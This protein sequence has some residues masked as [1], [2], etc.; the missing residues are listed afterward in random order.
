MSLEDISVT[1]IAPDPGL[2]GNAWPLMTEILE[3]VRRLLETGE[4]TAI[5]LSALPLTPAD[6]TW[7]KERLGMGQ[8]R[9]QLE[10]EGLSSLDETAC[11][12]VWWVTHRDTRD[13]LLSEFIE[14]A[15][16]PE[17]VH[18]HPD[19]VRMGQEYLEGIVSELS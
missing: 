9:V 2:S 4:S 1:V 13:R 14:I 12:G 5:D 18:A 6:K 8:I 17:L 3:M 10:A 16:V 19:D 7:L 15:F 11:P